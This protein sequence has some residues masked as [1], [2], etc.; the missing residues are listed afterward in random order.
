[1]TKKMNSNIPVLAKGGFKA[2]VEINDKESLIIKIESPFLESEVQGMFA[3][4]YRTFKMQLAQ[5][6][7]Y[8]K[9]KK[10]DKKIIYRF[11]YVEE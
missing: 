10:E 1:M 5:T 11:E 4:E 7:I 2:F 3:P 9:A 6:D 8:R